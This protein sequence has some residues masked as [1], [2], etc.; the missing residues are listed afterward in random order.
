MGIGGDGYEEVLQYDVL[1][2]YDHDDLRDAPS[3]FVDTRPSPGY[4]TRTCS[5]VPGRTQ[6]DICA[7]R[8]SIP[9]ASNGG[10]LD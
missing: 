8:R 9:Q 1:W 6:F 10:R 7:A 2:L 3:N 5:G 4:Y